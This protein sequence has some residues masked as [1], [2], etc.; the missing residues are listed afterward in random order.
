M[1]IITLRKPEVSDFNAKNKIYRNGIELEKGIIITEDFLE[2]N[3]ALLED[4]MQ[5]FVS[6]PDIYLDFIKP[7][8]SNFDLFPFQRIFLRACMRYRT[9]YITAA[10]ATSKSFL[11]ILAKYLQC[12]F[13]PGHKGFIVAPNKN[14]AAIFLRFI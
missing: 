6:Y 1:S 12:I 7:T 14:Q 9:I 8:E 4:T 10:R 13:I 3:A 11:S 2:R 5:K